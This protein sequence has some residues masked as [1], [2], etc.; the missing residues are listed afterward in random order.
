MTAP[1][2]VTG[3][4][5]GIGLA[6]VNELLA[7][8]FEVLAAVRREEDR[9][10]LEA[11]APRCTGLLLDV[12]VPEDRE[13]VAAAL[14]YQLSGRGLG[15]VV[16][17][18][19]IAIFQPVEALGD[20]LLQQQFAVNVFGAVALT[21]LLLPLL[22]EGQGRIVHISS[23]AGNLSQPYFGAYAASKWALEAF[24]DALRLELAPQ[25]IHVVSV[26]PGAIATP[27]WEKSL[28]QSRSRH[29][30]MPGAL[31]DLYGADLDRLAQGA[32]ML[33]ARGIPAARV[34]R[35]VR[36]VFTVRH[37]AARYRVGPDARLGP[38]LR[39]LPDSWRDALLRRVLG[40]GG[41]RS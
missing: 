32:E 14:A 31:R 16:H 37:P 19:G 1:I 7:S 20:D 8:G 3:A 35:V 9:L 40:L 26:Q 29:T 34:A 2:L 11:L 17:N 10:R 41:F 13:R 30:A 6:I 15:G 36:H 24:S 12:A 21:R 39:V 23:L 28:E 25:G 27:I 18:A 4:S 38:W 22:R 5:T 33:G